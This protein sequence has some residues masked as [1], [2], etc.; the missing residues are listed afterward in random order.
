MP[1]L[2]NGRWTQTHGWQDLRRRSITGLKP[3]WFSAC[4]IPDLGLFPARYPEVRTVAFHAG[5]EL[6]FLHLSLW[7]LSWPVRWGLLPR[8]TA[9]RNL[10]QPL[11]NVTAR[12]GSDRGGMFVE[13]TGRHGNGTPQRLIWELTARSGDG[14]YIPTI[15][16]ALLVK[17]LKS[18]T[19]SATGAGPC[20]GFITLPEFLAEIEDLDV[21]VEVKRLP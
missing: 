9:F 20:L 21:S 11:A 17:K 18:G 15:A 7:A 2:Q 13:L 6:G 4:D 1:Q 3:R 16:A 14:P 5:L 8:L 12:L 19:L 10:L